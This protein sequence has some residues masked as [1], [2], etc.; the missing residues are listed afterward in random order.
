M[1][2]LSDSCFFETETTE[3]PMIYL[4]YT[5]NPT[6]RRHHGCHARKDPQ[7]TELQLG[8]SQHKTLPHLRVFIKLSG[9][10]NCK[11]LPGPHLVTVVASC[12][13]M[14]PC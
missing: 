2:G 9:K 10:R 5:A 8:S 3:H 4:G 6:Q 1:V 11:G 7:S 12:L 13:Y 14:N